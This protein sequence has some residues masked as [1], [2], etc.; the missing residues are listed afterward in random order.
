[1][2]LYLLHLPVDYTVERLM[3]TAEL[4]VRM[5]IKLGV[6]LALASSSYL[7]VEQPFLRL[8]HGFESKAPAFSGPVPISVV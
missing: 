1:M 4:S 7:W 6:S 8:K 2:M 5:P 3:P